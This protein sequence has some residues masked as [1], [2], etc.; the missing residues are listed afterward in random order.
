MTIQMHNFRYCPAA[1][2]GCFVEDQAYAAVPTTGEPVASTYNPVALIDVEAG[3]QVVFRYEDGP[4][5]LAD[6]LTC[7]SFAG[8]PV[9]IDL[10]I[11]QLRCPGHSVVL[12]AAGPGGVRQSLGFLPQGGRGQTI[13]WNVPADLAPGT[14]IPFFCDVGDGVHHRV[15]MTGAL[16]VAS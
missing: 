9:G 5:G 1:Q 10:G 14:V 2:A 8:G 12:A 6:P 4:A 16:R 13:A 15:G 7:D 11:S 3:A